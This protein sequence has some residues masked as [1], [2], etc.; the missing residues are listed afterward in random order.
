MDEY[1]ESRAVVS[2]VVTSPLGVLVGRRRDGV[3][4]WTFTGGHIE[5]G[6]TPQAAA[7]REVLEEAGLS[8]VASAGEIGRRVHPVTGR[9]IVYVACRAAGAA[10]V[11][12]QSEL[13]EVRWVQPDVLEELMPDVFPPALAYVRDQCV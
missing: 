13:A 3:P 10:A 2:A 4:P 6:E 8:V 11:A 9:L 12:D 7:E 1:G 5:D